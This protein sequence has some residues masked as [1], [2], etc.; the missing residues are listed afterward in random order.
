MR[1]SSRLIKTISV[2]VLIAVVNVYAF[3]NGAIVSSTESASAKVLLGKLIT[4]SNRPIT[5]NGADA[6]TGTVVLSGAQLTTPAASLATVQLDG[7]GSVMIAPRSSVTLNFDLKSVTV[8]VASGDATLTTVEGVKG[9]VIGPDGKVAPAAPAAPA[10]AGGNSAKNW[11][12]AGVAIG[13]AGLI[14]A[15]IA[16]NRANK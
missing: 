1:P 8:K 5:V 6:I 12:I 10:P 4:T 13:S 14:W 15:L 16:W 7:L 9:V 11:A 3:A 2:L